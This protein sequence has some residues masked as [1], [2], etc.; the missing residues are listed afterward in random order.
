MAAN[1]HLDRDE[2]ALCDDALLLMQRLCDRL[3]YRQKRER[4]SQVETAMAD[5]L[6]AARGVFDE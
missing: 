1:I 2:E 5:L 4:A 3:V 6:K